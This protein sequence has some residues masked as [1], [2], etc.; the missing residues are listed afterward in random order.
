MIRNV[1]NANCTK[2]DFSNEKNILVT[3]Q[4]RKAFAASVVNVVVKIIQHY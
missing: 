4:K 3:G 2:S 1:E